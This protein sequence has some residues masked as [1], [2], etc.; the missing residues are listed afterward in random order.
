MLHQQQQQQQMMMAM[1]NQQQQQSQALL[2]FV[3]KLFQNN[4]PGSSP[5]YKQLNLILYASL[6][7]VYVLVSVIRYIL[8]GLHR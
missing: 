8:Y 3:E 4:F 2:T 5:V 1:I 7:N 6:E